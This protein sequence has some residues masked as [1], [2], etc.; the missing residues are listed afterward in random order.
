MVPV[1]SDIMIFVL[2]SPSDVQFKDTKDKYIYS[3]SF[4]TGSVAK[5]SYI[6][7]IHRGGLDEFT[8]IT[9]GMEI[10]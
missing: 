6:R 10:P 1:K 5:F 3:A 8:I 4:V 7:T 9:S 2:V